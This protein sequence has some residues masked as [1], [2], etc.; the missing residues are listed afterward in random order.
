MVAEQLEL[1]AAKEAVSLGETIFVN[2][3][4]DGGRALFA[5][6]KFSGIELAGKVSDIC[7][8]DIFSHEASW[9]KV[10]GR[11]S[12]NVFKHEATDSPAYQALAMTTSDA[13][14]TAYKVLT[15]AGQSPGAHSVK[16][17][18]PE[19]EPSGQWKPGAWLHVD[20]TA[21]D[22]YAIRGMLRPQTRRALHV[23]NVPG[24]WSLGGTN[25]RVFE[26]ELNPA[27]KAYWT[28]VTNEGTLRDESPI[29]VSLRDFPAR[30]VRLTRE[31]FGDELRRI[32]GK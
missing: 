1:L 10:L 27:D 12:A 18:L 16:W 19:L 15:E 6:A 7:R 11:E 28:K 20:D 22:S 29:P 14:T 5:E 32:L 31:L 8:E 9:S 21:E 26:A 25:M 17:S 4:A 3:A 23:S 13:R 2:V 24:E 30:E